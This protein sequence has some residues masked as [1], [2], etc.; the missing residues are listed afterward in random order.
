M[1]PG[2]GRR[3]CYISCKERVKD[4]LVSRVHSQ[5]IVSCRAFTTIMKG[6]MKGDKGFILIVI[7]RHTWSSCDSDSVVPRIV[8]VRTTD[9]VV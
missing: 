2:T 4:C 5:F 1:R 9:A 7:Y 6:G 8:S 3:I